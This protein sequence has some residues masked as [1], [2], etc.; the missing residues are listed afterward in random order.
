MDAHSEGLLGVGR[1]KYFLCFAGAVFIQ[2]LRV[3]VKKRDV[4][5]FVHASTYCCMPCKACDPQPY[6]S[7]HAAEH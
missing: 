1:T 5:L 2:T 6:T 4:L 7:A 3:F